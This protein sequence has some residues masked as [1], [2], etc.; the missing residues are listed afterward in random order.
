MNS[1]HETELD[2]EL[3]KTMQDWELLAWL[4]KIAFYSLVAG[5]AACLL[6]R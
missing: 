2:A 6:T 4:S 1:D 5:A 3:E